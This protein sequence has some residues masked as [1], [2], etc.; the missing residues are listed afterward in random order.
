MPPTA[1]DLV[2]TVLNRMPVVVPDYS[3]NV[4]QLEET[5]HT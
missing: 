5:K 1:P 3:V 2:T 4:L